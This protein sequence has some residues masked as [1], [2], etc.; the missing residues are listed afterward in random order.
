MPKK[1][2]TD[3]FIKAVK[4]PVSGRDVYV[5]ADPRAQGLELIVSPGGRRS[6]SIRY[7]V[8][9]ERRR[10]GFGTY[11]T[12]GL[13][14][15]RQRAHDIS[16][17]A[18]KGIDLP[19]QETAAAGPM[20]RAADR[21]ATVADLL[22]RYV[23][24]YCKVH[25]RRWKLTQRMFDAH[26]KPARIGAIEIP[27]L[28]RADV[29]ELLDDLQNKKG[30]AAQVNRVRSQLVAAFNWAIEREWLETNP[31]AATKKRKVEAA[32]ERVLT[33]DELRAVWRAADALGKPSGPFIKMLILTGQR[34]DEI[35][36]MSWRE[37]DEKAGVWTLPAARNKGKRDH[38][39]PLSAAAAA[40]V[41]AQPKIG[42][43]VFTVSGEKPYAGTKRLKQN[44]DRLSGVN[45]WVLH[46]IRRTVR[47]G[48]AALHVPEEVAERVLNH[49][50]KGLAKVYDRHSYAA[51]MRVALEKWAAH[52][53]FL[54]GDAR[55]AENVR[56]LRA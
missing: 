49:A 30:F 36:C 54:V 22:D 50:K 35:R 6:W 55:D 31:A 21:P 29:V 27:A 51:E 33:D 42:K 32:R 17:A 23:E 10:I 3:R 19:A 48:L 37:I 9:G 39:L 15:A 45:D 7:R 1:L 20:R 8:R 14:E 2:L 24:D 43:Y 38:A 56:R 28:R 4:P 44:L 26:V 34:R 53:A 25:Q 12:A 16:N 18:L 5:D 11:P 52:V 41:D 13:A 47:S 40:L 46:D